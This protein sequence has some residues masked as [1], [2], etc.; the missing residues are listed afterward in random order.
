M[1]FNFEVVT[2]LDSIPRVFWAPNWTID[3]I[4]ASDWS[5]CWGCGLACPFCDLGHAHF[6][7]LR[8]PGPVFSSGSE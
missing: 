2:L 5:G 7:D 6:S 3:E 1:H 4:F 8:L